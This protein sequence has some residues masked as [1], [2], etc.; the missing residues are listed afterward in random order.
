LGIVLV[1]L[2]LGVWSTQGAAAEQLEVTLVKLTSPVSRG[3]IVTITIKSTTGAECKG[4][5]R[6]RQLTQ[7]L[8]PKTTNDEGTATWSWRV[9]SDARGTYPIEIEC[10]QGDKKGFLS[11]RLVV[12]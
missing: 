11:A 4:T 6:Y 3:S 10:A 2:A 12:D 5:V 8:A 7:S 1:L 9:G